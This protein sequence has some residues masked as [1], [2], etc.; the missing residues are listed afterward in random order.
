[1]WEGEGTGTEKVHGQKLAFSLKGG[2]KTAFR[3]TFSETGS[4]DFWRCVCGERG[5]EAP[6]SPSY[7]SD[8]STCETPPPKVGQS[9]I[10]DVGTKLFSVWEKHGNSR[11]TLSE[12]HTTMCCVGAEKTVSVW[13]PLNL[14]VGINVPRP[15][16]KSF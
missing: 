7:I 8:D 16:K 9:L 6:S 1:M 15:N 5:T 11:Q 13:L 14:I 3:Q 4:D 10:L 2:Q 12:R